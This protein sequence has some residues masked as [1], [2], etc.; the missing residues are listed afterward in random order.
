MGQYHDRRFPNES[1][2]YR[3]ARDRLLEAEMELR[4]L[5]ESVA[6]QRR[7]LP[8]G[9]AVTEDYSFDEVDQK[10]GAV[11]P[12]RLAELFDPGKEALVLYG[13]MFAPEWE[14]PCPACTSLI[15][16]FNGAAPQVRARVNHAVV[17]KAPPEKLAALARARGWEDVRLLSSQS[18]SYNQ[19]Y[20][21]EFKGQ[22]SDHHPMI[23]VFVKRD[24][25]ISHFWAS[26]LY[27][28]PENDMHPRHADL[29]WP[30]WAYFDLTPEGRGDFFPPVL[31]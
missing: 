12:V 22:W 25:V 28:V 15:D 3:E 4:R 11:R 16:C 18:N 29:L 27:F 31:D 2:A 10:N 26:E 23:N 8:L 14:K 7:A 1:D 13:F 21:T 6:M 5:Q 20:M 17:A 9:G 24:G 19:D 30:I